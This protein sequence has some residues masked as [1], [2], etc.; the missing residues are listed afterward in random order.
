M[1]RN[2]SFALVLVAA[3]G[4]LGFG[5]YTQQQ[6]I[7]ALSARVGALEAELDGQQDRVAAMLEAEGEALAALRQDL[8]AAHRATL[9]TLDLERAAAV[10]LFTADVALLRTAVMDRLAAEVEAIKSL[11]TADRVATDLLE[12]TDLVD[13]VASNLWFYHHAELA[14]HPRLIASVAAGVYETYGADLQGP[15][16]ESPRVSEI[17]AAL[18]VEPGFADLVAQLAVIKGTE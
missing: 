2:V 9:E 16:G 4:A 15:A 18:A 14:E 10:D 13:L 1:S 7:D 17:A 6:T 5:V 8:D 3:V 11:P 12:S